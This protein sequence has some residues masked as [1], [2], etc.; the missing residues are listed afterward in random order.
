[1]N[2][3]NFSG[4]AIADKNGNPTSEFQSWMDQLILELQKNA[5]TEGLT[6]VSLPT[7]DISKIESSDNKQNGTFIYDSDTD[8]VKVNINGT[9][10]TVQVA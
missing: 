5:G 4:S 1:M 7:D 9:F 2:I 3:P 10:K 8:E 6:P